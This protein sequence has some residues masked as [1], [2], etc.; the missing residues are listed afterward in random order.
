LKQRDV[1]FQRLVVVTALT[2]ACS[3]A[4]AGDDMQ[5]IGAFAI[6]RSEVTIGDFRRFVYATGRV[7]KAEHEGGGHVYEAGWT[8]K[9]GWNWLAPY[10]RAGGSREPVVHVTYAEA[11][12]YCQWAGKRLPNDAEWVEAAYTERRH[13]PS[14]PFLRGK[15][16]PYPT[17]DSPQGAHCLDDCGPVRPVVQHAGLWRGRGHVAAGTTRRGVNGLYD[18]GGNV[19]EWVDAGDGNEKR[20]RGGSWW[21]GAAQME[22]DHVANKPADFTAV[23]IGFRC[24][25]DL[26]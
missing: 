8:R 9:P 7:T 14:P 24:A 2:A 22:A 5:V 10:G 12:A 1:T 15:T 18:M 16:Y 26:K 19:W 3:P 13:V 6:D 20:T 25:R 23:Y 17:G 21:Y 11:E 4:I